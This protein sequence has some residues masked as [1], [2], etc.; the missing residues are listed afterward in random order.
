LP[1]TEAVIAKRFNNLLRPLQV[2]INRT[3]VLAG[4]LAEIHGVDKDVC[5]LAAG[6]HDLFRSEPDFAQIAAAEKYGIPIGDI[7]AITP[8][9]LHGP[10][11]AAWLENEAGLMDNRV[12]EAVR[13][14]TFGWPD[15]DDVGKILY[16]A[17]KLEPGKINADPTLEPIRILAE[18]NPDQALLQLLQKRYEA[19]QDRGLE[20]H[21][22]T[23]ALIENLK[24]N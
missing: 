7:E 2:H 21:P 13:W 5:E 14:H 12:L 1:S 6:T 10:I 19:H 16:L 20:V 17:D 11:A 15:I 3:T 24:S 22:F 9:L 4:E 8:M 23:L 18:T